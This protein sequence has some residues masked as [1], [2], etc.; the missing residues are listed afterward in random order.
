MSTFEFL[1]LESEGPL[2]TVWL[3]RPPVNSVSQAMYRELED[4]FSRPDRHLP[5]V[6]AIVLAGE[7]RHFCAGNDLHEFGTLTPDNSD[8]RMAEVRAAFF[9]IQECPVPVIGAVHGVALG[10]GLAIAASCD[11]VIAAENARFGTPEVGVGIMGGA[12]HLARLVPEPI[13]RWMYLTG[14]PIEAGRLAELG[15]IVAVVPPTELIKRAHEQ[16]RRIVRHSSASIRMAKRSLTGI[17]TMDLQEGYIFEQGLTRELSRH[18]DSLE[19]RRAT[20]EQRA[21]RYTE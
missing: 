5:G 6:K 2:S 20:L 15:G 16:A 14:D 21:A 4:L 18:P 10:T 12:R 1:R 13:V 17:E 19:A 9:A 11:F 3:A 8:E 7:G